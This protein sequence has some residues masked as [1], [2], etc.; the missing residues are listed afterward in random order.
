MDASPDSSLTE[1][2]AVT[3]PMIM[4]VA[5][6]ATMVTGA[7]TVGLAIQ[8]SLVF[9]MRGFVPVAVGGMLLLGLPALVAGFG[10]LRGRGGATIAAAVASALVATLGS[11]WAVV[12]LMSGLISPLSFGVVV[13]AV[14]SAVLAG[15]AIGPARKVTHARAALRA[16]GLD[17]GL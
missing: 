3:V 15:V 9:R 13:L 6:G 16:R 10:T 5:A 8:T 4:K 14:G 2:D 12:G 11:V 1:L 7:F 17:F